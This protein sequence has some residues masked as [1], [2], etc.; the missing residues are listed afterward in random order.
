MDK[1]RDI[2]AFLNPGQVPVIAADKPIYAVA[3]QIQCYWPEMYGKDKF[4]LM[5]GGLHIE[6]TALRSI[7]TFKTVVGQGPLL[8]QG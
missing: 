6:M 1:I 8:K 4:M 5:F 3:K 2:V 7:G